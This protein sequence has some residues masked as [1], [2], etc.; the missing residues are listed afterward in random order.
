MTNTAIPGDVS[1]FF[2]ENPM[3]DLMVN[4]P[5]HVLIEKYKLKL[6][7]ACLASPEQMPIMDDIYNTEGSLA[8]PGGSAL[9]SARTC[10]FT[11][12]K[13][14]K[15][16]VAFM[17]SIGDDIKG[18]T[19]VNCLESDGITEVMYRAENA[20]TATCAV[21]VVRTERTLC[22]ALEACSLLPTS[23]LIENWVRDLNLI[24]AGLRRSSIIPLHNRF[25]HLQQQRSS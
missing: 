19:L 9:N 1:I 14:G 18:R 25:F 6:G 12:K 2:I 5:D 17:G 15:G 7:M 21:V 8:T 20:K 22:C 23:H 11:M 10:N 24:F 4:D 13:H 3:L 16:K